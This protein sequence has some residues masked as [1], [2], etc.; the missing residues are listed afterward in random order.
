M[1]DLALGRNCK[2]TRIFL[3]CKG[4]PILEWLGNS[5]DM[6]P[7]ENTWN[8]MKKVIGNQLMLCK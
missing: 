4:I 8:I 6:N 7:I 1:H 5:P 3:E 2:S